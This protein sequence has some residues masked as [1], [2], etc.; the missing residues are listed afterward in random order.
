MYPRGFLERALSLF[1][2]VT[3]VLHCPSGTLGNLPKGH[4]TVDLISDNARQPHI[5]ANAASLP[6][7]DCRFD[8]ILSDPPYS[9]NDAKKYGTPVFPEQ[10]FLREAF[11]VLRF[12]G[13]L[14]VLHKYEMQVPIARL[15]RVA[16]LAIS[17]GNHKELRTFAIYR[18]ES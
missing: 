2:G 15:K 5:R 17:L 16:L 10:Q 13:Y 9:E 8:L 18:K 7:A 1:N 3:H 11:R 12:G 6:F 14:G 4:V